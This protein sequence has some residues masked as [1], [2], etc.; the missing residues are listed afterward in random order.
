MTDPR[1]N[2]IH[3]LVTSLSPSSL[4]FNMLPVHRLPQLGWHKWNRTS[5]DISPAVVT[6]TYR[7]SAVVDHLWWCVYGVTGA[8]LAAEVWAPVVMCVRSHSRFIVT[9]CRSTR[10]IH[11]LLGLLNWYC[12]Y[13]GALLIEVVTCKGLKVEILCGY[14][15]L[16]FRFTSEKPFHEDKICRGRLDIIIFWYS[17]FFILLDFHFPSE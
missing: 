4:E 16:N 7:T 13:E 14:F 11:H 1:L 8:S 3:W 9:L 17:V 10:P 6:V 2:V 5:C 15:I 12:L